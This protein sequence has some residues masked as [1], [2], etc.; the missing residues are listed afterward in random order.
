MD[1]DDLLLT[2]VRVPPNPVPVMANIDGK[3]VQIG[4][5]T[6]DKKTGVFT[7]T[8]NDSE[9]AEIV[10]NFLKDSKQFSL[11]V[12]YSEVEALPWSNL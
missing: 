11:P 3:R 1:K 6:L 10:Q 2:Y 5:G 7:T 9:H 8:F 4:T 12:Q